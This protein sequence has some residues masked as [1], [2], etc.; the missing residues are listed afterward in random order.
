MIGVR[1]FLEVVEASL[2]EQPN[3]WAV[4][5]MKIAN[6]R[7]GV[8]IEHYGFIAVKCNGA[9]MPLPWGW[10]KRIRRAVELCIA[11]QVVEKFK[12]A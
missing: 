1:E 10:R 4:S 2:Q 9:E 12:K 3:D 7:V 6:P 8:V 5:E 11:R